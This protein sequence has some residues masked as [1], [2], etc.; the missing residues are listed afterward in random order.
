MAT[1]TASQDTQTLNLARN[2]SRVYARQVV[3]DD[4]AAKPKFVAL[5]STRSLLFGT[6]SLLL[7]VIGNRE[8]EGESF[9]MEYNV[10]TF[11]AL[12]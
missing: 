5:K 6:T 7:K 2:L 12:I 11:K 4:R 9:C 8:S 3:S 10:A 1:R